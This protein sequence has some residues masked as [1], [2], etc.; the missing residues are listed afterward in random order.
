MELL[1]C[2]V[3]LKKILCFRMT[4]LGLLTLSCIAQECERNE[5]KKSSNAPLTRSRWGGYVYEPINRIEVLESQSYKCKNVSLPLSTCSLFRC[6]SCSSNLTIVSLRTPTV[7]SLSFSACSFLNVINMSNLGIEIILPAALNPLDELR[8]LYLS[9]NKIHRLPDGLLNSLTKLEVLDLSGNRLETVSEHFMIGLGNMRVLNLSANR[10]VNFD[11]SSLYSKKKLNVD[12]S[13]NYITEFNFEDASGIAQ[14]LNLSHNLIRKIGGCLSLIEV[15]ILQHNELED[16]SNITCQNRTS[17]LSELD[18]GFNSIVE[19]PG[20]SFE[21]VQSLQY[22]RL[23]SNNMS[24]LETSLFTNLNSLELLNLSSNHLK[25]FQHGVFE[26][27]P[28]LRLLDLSQN[29]ILDIKRYFHSLTNLEELDLR[30]NNIFSLDFSQLA[31][32]LPNLKHVSLE[33]NSLSCKLLI[34]MFHNAG[35]NRSILR[36]GG[37]KSSSNVHGIAC[38]E[39]EEHDKFNTSKDKEKTGQRDSFISRLEQ[40]FSKYEESVKSMNDFYMTGFN[41]S[42]FLQSSRCDNS[43]RVNE[44]EFINHFDRDFFID[45]FNR[46]FENSSFMQYLENLRQADNFFHNG[47]NSS[48]LY[49]FFNKDFPK[50]Q[51]YQYLEKLFVSRNFEAHA[52]TKD[53]EVKNFPN[54]VANDTHESYKG[55]LLIIVFLLTIQVVAFCSLTVMSVKLYLLLV[56]S[57]IKT[58][59]HIELIDS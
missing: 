44:T 11:T 5:I 38:N 47:F 49:N 31:L 16:I 51:F 54:L 52:L 22:L 58:K 7:P 59:E 29:N 50:S 46:G 6:E 48:R 40:F 10:L 45:Y 8:E 18:L 35:N 43:P 33:G 23:E 56:K 4:L 20:N 17:V 32:D 14:S 37:T 24:V 2:A 55:I 25:N 1:T 57:S 9:K 41:G 28:H 19:L 53:F 21:G 15:I 26:H 12:L 13:F 30:N 39:I 27:L 3:F 42:N 34:D 36:Y